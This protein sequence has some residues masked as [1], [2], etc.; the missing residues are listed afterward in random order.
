MRRRKPTTAAVDFNAWAL[1]WSSWTTKV[2]GPLLLEAFTELDVAFMN[3][4]ISITFR[5]KGLCI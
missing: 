5:G 2:R 3:V 4:R 1:G